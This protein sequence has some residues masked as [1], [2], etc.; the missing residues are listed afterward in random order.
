MV[1][2]PHLDF[3]AVA[4]GKDVA[5]Q[6]LNVTNAGD[7]SL[8]VAVKTDQDW[9]QVTPEW[10]RGIS[11]DAVEQIQVS[12]DAKHLKSRTSYSGYVVVASPGSEMWVPVYVRTLP[13]HWQIFTARMRT[14]MRH[15]ATGLLVGSLAGL[16]AWVWGQVL[17][18]IL[19]GEGN[20]NILRDLLVATAVI[21][22]LVVSAF[23]VRATRN[24]GA[25]CL[26]GILGAGLGIGVVL[27]GLVAGKLSPTELAIGGALVGFLAGTVKGLTQKL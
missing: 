23:A 12:V 8:A 15:A 19:L 10:F 17:T 4:L 27:A 11:G 5:P 3:G 21:C 13:T 16:T 2:P 20:G 6:A 22:A 9:I 26:A 7:G 25:S 18:V 1:E 14:T 24:V